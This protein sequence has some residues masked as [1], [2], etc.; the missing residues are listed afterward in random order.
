MKKIMIALLCAIVVSSASAA[1]MDWNGTVSGAAIATD[2]NANFLL[3]ALGATSS[4]FGNGDF[5]VSTLELDGQAALLGDGDWT[6]RTYVAG[7][8]PFPPTT[9]G[10]SY[11]TG[12]AAINQ[13]YALVYYDAANDSTYGVDVFEISGATDTGAPVGITSAINGAS[14]TTVPEPTSM[15]LLAIGIAALGLRRR[16]SK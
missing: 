15:A 3:F 1:Q 4:A 6:T 16:I 13:W 10:L 8:V 11:V 12:E 9:V 7:G 5:N 14:F 2:A